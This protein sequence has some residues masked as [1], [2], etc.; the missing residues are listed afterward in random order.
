M[1]GVC[2]LA[3]G[4]TRVLIIDDHPSMR[5]ILRGLLT[6]LGYAEVLDAE[7]GASAIEKMRERRVGLVI[8]EWE[9]RPISG[10]DFLKAVR[11]HALFKDTPVIIVTNAPDASQL[12]AAREAGANSYIVKPITVTNL[13]QKIEA[14][15][16]AAALV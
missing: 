14:V 9:M 2:T 12:L 16:S 5:R 13:K 1:T 3:G 11:A 10:L 7:D 15:M 8:A 4:K 6:H